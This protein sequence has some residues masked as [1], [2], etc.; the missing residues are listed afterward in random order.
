MAILLQTGV[1]PGLKHALNRMG[2]PVGSC[3]APFSPPDADS[4]LL[5]DQ[6]LDD[7]EY[8]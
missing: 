1:I 3:R 7:N 5:L 6:W 2:I 4:L 8:T